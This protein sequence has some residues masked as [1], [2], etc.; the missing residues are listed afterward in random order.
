MEENKRDKQD[1]FAKKMHGKISRRYIVVFVTSFLLAMMLVWGY[2]IEEN[3]EVFCSYETVMI[4]LVL[5]LMISMG[6][7]CVF[8]LFDRLYIHRPID[9]TGR[10]YLYVIFGVLLLGYLF[11]FLVFYPGLFV[12]DAEWHFEMYKWVQDLTE[13]HTVLHTL[14]L[15]GIVDNIYQCT[16]RFNWGVAVYI[17]LQIVLCS[18][19]FSYMLGYI[20]RRLKS[21]VL[22]AVSII[23][24][25]FYPPI[26]LQ[27]MSATKDTMFLPFLILVVVLSLEMIEN[28]GGFVKRPLK[29]FLWIFSAVF[30]IIFRNNCIYAVPVLIV[31]LFIGLKSQRLYFMGMLSG[32]FVLLLIYKCMVV[33]TVVT[34]EVDGREL[35]SVPIQQLARIYHTEDADILAEEKKVIELLLTE[36]GVRLYHPK[37]ADWPKYCFDMNYY[38]DNYKDVNAMYVDLV[39]RNFKIAAESFLENTCGYWY[40]GSE[41]VLSFERK[42]YWPMENCYLCETNSKIPAIFNYYLQFH[43][44]EYALDKSLALI[45]YAPATFFLVFMIM[46]AYAIDRRKVKYIS[47]FSFILTF[48]A[49]YLLGPVALVRYTVYLFVMLPLYLCVVC[50]K[51]ELSLALQVCK[52]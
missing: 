31:M 40:P 26:V 1:I 30:M 2:Q 51:D 35:L 38:N 27:V 42:G 3:S 21:K 50:E 20:Y 52:R 33:P 24:L 17:L 15:G 5:L 9:V 43:T 32:V 8:M 22:V 16:G 10:K 25:A 12:F 39:G 18:F 47:V 6:I 46:F 7:Y 37:I 11:H 36:K 13:H 34:A 14:I 41:L 44:S 19:A 48:W 45:L 4:F 23:F 29:V 28:T 49:T